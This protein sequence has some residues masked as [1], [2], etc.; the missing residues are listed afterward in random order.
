MKNCLILIVSVL[1]LALPAKADNEFGGKKKGGIKAK[2]TEVPSHG[3]FTNRAN[4]IEGKK[5]FFGFQAGGALAHMDA[6]HKEA[7]TFGVCGNLFVYGV[8][9]KP[10]T[11]AMGADLG[12]FYLFTSKDKY[13]R[14]LTS[15]NRD[16]SEGTAPE[17]SVNNWMIPTAQISFLGNFHPL[18]RFNIQIKLT[19]GMAIAMIPGNNATYFQKEVQADGSYLEAKYKY[20]DTKGMKFGFVGGI[21]TD[22]LY[23]LSC[24]SELKAGI[25][26]SYV[27]FTYERNWELP[28]A[29]TTKQLTQFGIFDIHIGFAFNF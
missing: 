6:T 28:V 24:H 10:Q 12:V 9:A 26:W 8:F 25:D 5:V 3:G 21:G 11:F 29:K 13:T 23:A 7:N 19:M 16:G 1:L 18:Q 20:A 17:I 22:L 4:G 15:S 14:L 27:R 2:V